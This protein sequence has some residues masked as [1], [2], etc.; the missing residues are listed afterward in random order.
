MGVHTRQ[1]S[2]QRGKNPCN[3]MCEAPWAASIVWESYLS[4][5]SLRRS[6]PEMQHAAVVVL[7]K[8]GFL[9]DFDAEQWIRTT[10]LMLFF[11]EVVRQVGRREGRR[12]NIGIERE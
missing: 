8:L 2:R 3:F 1:R 4:R 11:V 12:R 10:D 6:H 5:D 7:Q 9:Q